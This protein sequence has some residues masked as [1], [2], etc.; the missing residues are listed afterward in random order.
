[1]TN[2]T[3]QKDAVKTFLTKKYEGAMTLLTKKRGARSF[4]GATPC[5]NKFCV[6]ALAMDCTLLGM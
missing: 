1:M 2:L 6:V 5:L 3:I 4:L